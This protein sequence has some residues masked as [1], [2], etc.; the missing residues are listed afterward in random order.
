MLLGMTRTPA[1]F[2]ALFLATSGCTPDY[3]LTPE[4]PDV[5]PGDVTECDFTRVG[6]SS[7]YEYDCNP[8]FT[9]SGEP[10]APSIGST[11]F[12]TTY[13][14]GHPFYQL[15]YVG[16][17]E[18]DYGNYGLGYAVSTNGTDWQPY[19]G[20]PLYQV[21]DPNAWNASGTDAVQVVYD[22]YVGSY[23]M[24]YQGFNI[25][26]GI[27]RMGVATSDDGLRWD[28]FE[29]PLDLTQGLGEVDQWCWP[30]G[31]ELGPNHGYQGFIAGG[32]AQLGQS[33]KCEVYQLYADNPWSWQPSVTKVLPVGYDGEWDDTGVISVDIEWL[34]G[35][36]L[37][38]YVGFS[39]WELHDGYVSSLHQYMGWAI[40]DD[41]VHW[42]KQGIVPIHKTA[43][44]QV[45]AVAANKV[46]RR[47]HL[48]VTDTYTDEGGG[49][50]TGIGLFLFDPLRAQEEDG[51]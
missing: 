32:S 49:E 36:G 8:V 39:D 45:G 26:A 20:N 23:V 13:V 7:F 15:W 50:E 27:W 28:H 44:G 16:G 41:G 4:A 10:W 14:S 40:S 24:I 11:T 9:T 21:N 37:M 29:P 51:Q 38:F 2:T 33:S 18:V 30:L 47:I 46:G 43:D 6:T 34:G 12:H 35:N 3:E 42:S 48:W 1:L 31:L 22:P 25:P 17:P 5:D 19:S